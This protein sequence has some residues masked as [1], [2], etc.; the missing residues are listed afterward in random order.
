[1]PADS[2][3]SSS[4][5]V[6]PD[7]SPPPPRPSASVDEEK[8]QPPRL[9]LDTTVP[10]DG[11]D[12]DGHV[13]NKGPRDLAT[14]TEPRPATEEPPLETGSASLPQQPKK[15][16]APEFPSM[17]T[18]TH[19]QLTVYSLVVFGT[20]WGVLARLGLQWIGGF[21]SS[22]VFSLVWAQMVG[23]AVMGF[24]VTKKNAIERVFPPLFVMCG[25]A[26]CGSLTTWSSMM[27]DVFTAFANLN[28][29]AGTSR[30]TGFMTGMGITLVTFF[31]AQAAFQGG[32]HLAHV[33]P[34]PSRHP[35]S[36]PAQ[37]LFNLTTIVIGPLFWLG[38]LMLLIFGPSS[39]RSRATF[40]IVVAPPGSIL[41]YLAS[42]HLNPINPRFPVGTLVVNSTSVLVFAVMALLAHHPRAPLGCAALKGVQ[43]GFCG[44]LSTISTMVVELRGL[45]TGDGYRYFAVSWCVAQ[46]L[47]VVVLGTWVWSGDRGELCW[48]R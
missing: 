24:C 30:F 5:T 32:I 2:T 23:C 37:G 42:K 29:P 20:I 45:R 16:P 7:S 19:T 11:A 17:Y 27:G 28:K 43:D 25:T 8:A 26:F 22:A 44:S 13:P 15:A 47:L 1:M 4:S 14:P 18:P 39:W 40:A 10:N 21:A 12:D 34:S 38:A 35:R 3:A 36:R 48:Q 31:S 9:K 33:V 41:R 6:H 46:A